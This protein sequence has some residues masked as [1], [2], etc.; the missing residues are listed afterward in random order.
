[1]SPLRFPGKWSAG[2]ERVIA[3]VLPAAGRCSRGDQQLP[4]TTPG[5]EG[6]ALDGCGVHTIP[7]PV[8][9]IRE[10]CERTRSNDLTVGF[11]KALDRVVQA[12]SLVVS[13]EPI[14]GFAEGVGNR[15][16]LRVDRVVVDR[17]ASPFGSQPHQGFVGHDAVHPGG[18]ASLALEVSHACR[19]QL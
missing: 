18:H 9:R 13:V 19:W 16:L 5:A 1:M 15:D 11:R 7:T 2:A 12:L 10:S 3:H 14:A 8:L 6:A 4:K 17:A